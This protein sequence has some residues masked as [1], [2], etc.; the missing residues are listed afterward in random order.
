MSSSPL[1][2][3]QGIEEHSALLKFTLLDALLTDFGLDEVLRATD[4]TAVGCQN[5]QLSKQWIYKVQQSALT[6]K[7]RSVG[8]QKSHYL[9]HM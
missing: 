1:P 9:L 2:T 8:Q 5:T 6:A 4:V 3:L 7:V